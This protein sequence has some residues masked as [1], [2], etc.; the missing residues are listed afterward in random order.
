MTPVRLLS[1]TCL[2]TSAVLVEVDVSP[3]GTVGQPLVKGAIKESGIRS[4]TALQNTLPSSFAVP[5]SRIDLSPADLRIDGTHWDLAAA[6]GMY[7]LALGTNDLGKATGFLIAGELAMN[8]AIRQIRGVLPMA[9]AAREAG[10]K[11]VIVPRGNAREAAVVQNIEVLGFSHIA[12]VIDWLKGEFPT[13][14]PPTLLDFGDQLN[15]G[16]ENPMVDMDQIR[17]QGPAKR[18][19]EI[20][21]AGGHNVLI[22][23]SPGCGKTMLARRAA[24]IAPLLTHDEAVQVTKVYSVA[25]LLAEGDALVTRRPFRAPHHT[26]SEA[27]L[28]GGGGIPRPGEASLA[29]TGVLFLDEVAEFK[30][31]TLEALRGAVEDKRVSVAQAAVRIAYP[32]NFMLIAATNPCPCGFWGDAE[33]RCAC[34][35]PASV[36]SF[37]RRLSGP[38]FDHIDVKIAM[39]RV[40]Y[41]DLVSKDSGDS[42]ATIRARVSAAR[43]IQ[44][45]RFTP[46]SRVQT[47]GAMGARAVREHC[48]ETL[49]P[50]SRA[51]LATVID[52]FGLSARAHD[53]ILRVARTISDLAGEKDVTVYAIAEAIPLHGL[54]A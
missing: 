16:L 33:K 34:T 15:A 51:I 40:K 21:V 52:K 5:H 3:S 23:G 44:R 42:S 2:G 1:A 36:E 49:S 27:G 53:R 19:M 37:R 46:L 26:I 13:P 17:G 39:P 32:A 11:G 35:P 29:H 50:E 41:R 6:L 48:A 28:L 43:E 8:G 14:V 54:E 31:Y 30:K 10:L 4:R 18:A 25:G 12:E 47:N 38:L 7:H 45:K 22:V 20:A 24:T 9:V